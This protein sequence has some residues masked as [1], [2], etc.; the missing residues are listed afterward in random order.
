M[1]QKVWVVTGGAR[2]IGKAIALAAAKQAD[3]VCILDTRKEQGEACL[4]QVEDA[5]GRGMFMAGDAAEKTV[6]EAF[7]Q[8]VVRDFGL[9]H[10]L[11]NNA[12]FSSRGLVSGCG[13]D[14]FNRVIH[15]GVTAPY[16]LSYLFMEHFASGASI[17]NLSSTRAFMSQRDTESYSAAKGGITSLTHAMAMS[18]AP[19]VRVNAI[20]PGWIDTRED[21]LAG[22]EPLYTRADIVQ[23]PSGR[24]G[25]P[26]DVV[27]AALFLADEKNSFINGETLIIDGGMSRRMIY[28]GDENWQYTPPDESNHRG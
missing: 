4:K 18:L 28:A 17:I 23:H 15:T 26:E 2:G 24:V 27:R 3:G 16:Y 10:V 19:R 9:V 1:D 21:S 6:L 8:V 22:G 13:W 20:A 5:G 7:A 14:D 25:R 11:V 12:C